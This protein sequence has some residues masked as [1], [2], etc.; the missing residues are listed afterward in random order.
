VPALFFCEFNELGVIRR[1]GIRA[2]LQ[3][4]D[5]EFEILGLKKGDAKAVDFVR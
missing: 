4:A 3:A 1:L 2:G 5:S